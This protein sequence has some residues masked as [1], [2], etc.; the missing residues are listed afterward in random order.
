MEYL[1]YHLKMLLRMT[2]KDSERNK[3]YSNVK[4]QKLDP[5]SAALDDAGFKGGA[6][7]MKLSK[8]VTRTDNTISTGV[9]IKNKTTVK[10]SKYQSDLRRFYEGFGRDPR[11]N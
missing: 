3:L 8:S 4:I 1:Y 7:K 6:S 5:L 2:K 9:P 10:Q 11:K